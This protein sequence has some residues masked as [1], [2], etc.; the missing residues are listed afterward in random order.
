MPENTIP[1]FIKAIE[2]GVNTLE[3]DLAVSQDG[4]LIVSHEPYIGSHLGLDSLGQE[5]STSEELSHNIFQMTYEQIKKYDVGSKF[6]ERFP[7]QQKMKVFK[8]SF[9]EVVDSVNAYLTTHSLA[10]VKYNIEIKSE[11]AWDNIFHPTPE[12][13]S[14]LVYDFINQK[15]DKK[16][17]NVQS[18]DF[19][20][21][22]Y[23]HNHFPEITLA[24]LIENQLS[25]DENLDALGFVPQI[26]SCEY[27]L[28]DESKIRYLQSKSMKVIPWTLNEDVDIKNMWTWGVDGI[29]SDYPDKVLK[30]I[31]K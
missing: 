25:I 28:L 17:V 29:I 2:L 18:F 23:F 21:L 14:K 12:V 16:L 8:P 30:I 5:I 20:I 13:F 15:M 27:I 1:A 22:Q 9:S 10:P 4:Q 11:P 24:V 7:S 6:V 26:Y 3:L 31:S 19:R